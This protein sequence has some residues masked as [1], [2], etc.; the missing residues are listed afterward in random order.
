MIS[1][2]TKVYSQNLSV[3]RPDQ[4]VKMCRKEIVTLL[5]S[6]ELLLAA[7]LAIKVICKDSRKISGF[8]QE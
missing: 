1:S 6:E 7:A 8:Q 3:K 5:S 4:A 2:G